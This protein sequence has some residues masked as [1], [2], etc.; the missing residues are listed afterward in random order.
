[1]PSTP[2]I[3]FTLDSL[4]TKQFQEK[5]SLLHSKRRGKDIDVRHLAI[6]QSP[7]FGNFNNAL[8]HGLNKED[9]TF[10]QVSGGYTS[11]MTPNYKLPKR[12]RVK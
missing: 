10:K 5:S 9:Q 1:M 4:R 2:K 11:W 12:K 8:I 6:N 7:A 3:K